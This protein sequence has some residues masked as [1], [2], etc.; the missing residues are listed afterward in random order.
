VN[1]HLRCRVEH[2]SP[3]VL[4]EVR[5]PGGPVVDVEAGPEDE[6]EAVVGRSHQAGLG[7]FGVDAETVVNGDRA[8]RH[9]GFLA[10]GV[11]FHDVGHDGLVFIVHA[12][13]LGHTVRECA[14]P[15]GLLGAL[16]QHSRVPS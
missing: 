13:A 2:A 6:A 10:A 15:L 12:D 1:A 9:P 5:F 11:D 14:A 7:P 3:L 4:V 16:L 8:P